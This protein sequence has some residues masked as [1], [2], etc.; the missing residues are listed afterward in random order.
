MLV[1]TSRFGILTTF[2]AFAILSLRGTAGCG[3]SSDGATE[4]GAGA[5]PTAGST[6][7][8]GAA[9]RAD[10]GAG[11]GAGSG[12]AGGAG[13]G[14]ASGGSA[15]RGG[16]AGGG[17]SDAGTPTDS[18]VPPAT[19]AGLSVYALECRGDSSD[20]NGASVPCFGLLGD[21]GPLGYACANRCE[22]ITDC[23]GAPSGA[24]AEVDCVQLTS[25]K[26]CLLVCKREQEMF[27]CPDGMGCYVYPGSPLGYCLW[28]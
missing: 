21:A 13:S 16:G 17:V 6:S 28:M 5:A 27:A 15:G 19:E 11:S 4:G 25:A 2:A 3:E 18:G 22:H 9:G 8:S 23:S 1:Q 7:T 24:E 20:C 14:S 10:S 12:G 26:H